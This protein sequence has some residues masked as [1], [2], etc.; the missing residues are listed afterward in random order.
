MQLNTIGMQLEMNLY[1]SHPIK[2]SLKKGK[3]AKKSIAS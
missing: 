1:P 2:D 3:I